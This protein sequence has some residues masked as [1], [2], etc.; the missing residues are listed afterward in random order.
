MSDAISRMGLLARVRSMLRG[1]S[2][3]PG[4]RESIAELVQEAAEAPH[5]PGPGA[6]A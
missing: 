5:A 2:A 1:R 6:G 4:V 3:E